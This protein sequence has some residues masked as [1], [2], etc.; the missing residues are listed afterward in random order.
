MVALCNSFCRVLTSMADFQL[1][2]KQVEA[3]EVLNG[4]ATHVMLAGGSRSGKTFQIIRKQVQRRLKAPGSRGAVLRFRTG[5]VRQSIVLD[6]F[7]TVMSK[8]FPGIDYD[9]NKSDLFATFPGGSELWFSGLDDKK[10]VE[11]VLGKEYSD[12]F[13]NECSQIP[14]ESRNFAVTRL[15]QKVSDRATGHDLVL[16]MYYD[17]N[18]PTKGHWTYRMFKLKQD[19]ETR[20]PLDAKDIDF[21]QINPRDNQAN[22][23]ASYLKTLEGLP[24]RLK[25]RFLYGE[26]GEEATNALF[27]DDWI[28]RWRNIDDELPDMLRIVVAVDP[29]GADDDDNFDSDAIGII[30]A[31][32]GIDGNGYVLEDLTV[33]AGPGVWGKVAVQAYQRWEADRIVAE[34]NFGGA[35]VKHV[36]K[37]AAQELGIV[38][39]YR[40]VKASRG[41][42]V[43]AEPVSALVETGRWRMAGVFQELEDELCA[44]TTHGYMGENSPNRMDAMVWAAADLFP[45]LT[46]HEEKPVE[47][48]PQLIV[49]RGS[50]T[51]W[52]RT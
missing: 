36:I 4:P 51:G 2:A 13:L 22:I 21:F 20:K 50:G 10:R 46:K 47:K 23:S 40:P 48:K 37:A 29:S 5:H 44:T 31:G 19:P 25:K 27:R 7:P 12:I 15:A 14:Y 45:E 38:V 11:K 39:P 16:K 33:K 1:T 8:C 28:E 24:E 30:V 49:R 34:D 6:T 35:M 3:Q 41:K 43:R 32:L 42:V 18:P 17:E 26:F 52:M 9:L